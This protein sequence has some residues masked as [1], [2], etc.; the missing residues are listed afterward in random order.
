MI[1]VSLKK[2]SLQSG[3]RILDIGCGAG[4]HVCACSRNAGIRVWGVDQCHADLIK[5]RENLN[6]EKAYGV[7]LGVWQLLSGDILHLPFPDNFFDLVICSEVLE[8]IIDDTAAMKEIIRVLKN[9][10]NLVVSVPRN[11]PERICWALSNEY[12]NTPGGHV[13]IYRQNQL[14]L[15]L[16][17]LGVKKWDSHHAHALHS[18][19][20]WMKCLVGLSKDNHICVRYYH[21]FLV[22]DMIHKSRWVRLI[23]NMLNPFIGKS[24]VLYFQKN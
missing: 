23:E 11:G 9:N 2:L 10:K 6:F 14:I 4:R 21:D 16:E 7:S 1:T 17:S 15:R 12:Q 18:I 8:H 5:A 20:W 3:D 19:L 22:W 24:L 13:R